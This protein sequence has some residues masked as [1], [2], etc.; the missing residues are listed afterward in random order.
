MIWEDQRKLCEL[1]SM[2]KQAGTFVAFRRLWFHHPDTPSGRA[3]QT[4]KHILIHV[5]QSNLAIAIA[6]LIK[7]SFCRNLLL[8]DIFYHPSKGLFVCFSKYSIKGFWRPQAL[9]FRHQIRSQL[10]NPVPAFL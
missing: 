1:K 5:P 2:L 8:L 4:G 10:H 9:L 3:S 7:N 6:R